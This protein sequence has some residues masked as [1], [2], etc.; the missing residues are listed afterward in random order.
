MLRASL[1]LA[2]SAASLWAAD[3]QC[4]VYP[5]E[6]R[7]AYASRIALN[8]GARGVLSGG[9]GPARARRIASSIQQADDSAP[10]PQRVNFVDDHIF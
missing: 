4:A 9:R 7:A 1:I 3:P 5:H 10:I 6:Q 8:V 2:M